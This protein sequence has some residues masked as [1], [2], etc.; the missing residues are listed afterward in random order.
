M[1]H[2]AAD[3]FQS[4][5]TCSDVQERDLV[6]IQLMIQEADLTVHGKFGRKAEGPVD[7][8]QQVEGGDE[9]AQ[10]SSL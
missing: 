7:V 9:A 5:L 10:R 8:S 2:P 6:R 3:C 4:T 1:L